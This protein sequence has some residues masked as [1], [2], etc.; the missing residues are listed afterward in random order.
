MVDV[1]ERG[2]PERLVS[3]GAWFLILMILSGVFWLA[4]GIIISR[5]YGP[6]GFG[7]YNTALSLHNFAWVVVFGGMFEGLIKYG[8]EYAAKSG[9]KLTNFFSTALKYLTAIGIILFIVISIAASNAKD[10]INR[11]IMYTI[12]FSFLFSGTKDALAAIIGSFQKSDHLSMLNS[13]RSIVV[14]LAS[15]AFILFGMPA[16]A[17]PF[18][19]VGATLWQLMLSIFFLRSRITRYLPFNIGAIFRDRHVV[20]KVKRFDNFKQF[21]RIFVFGSFISLGMVSFNIMK[22]LDI[23]VLKLFMDYADVGIYSIADASSSILFYMTSFTIPLIPA[24]SE[25]FAKRDKRLMQDYIKIAVKYPI[26][27]GVPLTVIMMTMAEPIVVGLYGRVFEEAVMPLQILIVGTFMLMFTY[28]LSSV[29][30]GIGRSSLSGLIMS[31]A[32][33]QYIFSLFIFVPAFKSV[34]LE[35][36]GAAFSLTLTGVTLMFMVPYMLKKRLGVDVYSGLSSVFLAAAVMALVLFLVPKSDPYVAFGGM[37]IGVVVFVASLY[38][39]G[40]ITREDLGMMRVAA[41]SFANIFR[42]KRK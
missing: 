32:A 39:M 24:I 2:G 42:R 37:V 10:P 12:A 5:H 35:F 27:I 28:N 16:E 21:G 40:Y 38:L 25:A 34:G 19:I 7:I 30:I 20:K 13:S 22:S 3:G 17:L 23:V 26:L 4:G 14:L 33:I 41:G 29:L 11:I 18:I 6:E 8:S 1:F 36:I 9:W 31:A 15:V